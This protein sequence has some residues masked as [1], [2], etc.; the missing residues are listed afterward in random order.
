MRYPVPAL[1]VALASF[2][3]SG[4]VYA[5][6]GCAAGTFSTVTSPDGNATSFL[7][8]DFSATAGGASGQKSVTTT[9]KLNVPVTQP[10]GHG[11]YAV[12]YR[13]F[14]T[15]QEGQSA[16]IRALQDGREVLR[17]QIQGP[18]DD[19]IAL[20]NRIGVSDADALG[21]TVDIRAA[22]PLDDENFEAGLFLDTID[23]A[24]IGFTTTDSVVESM[25]Q[26][27]RQRQSIAI[28]LMPVAQTLLGQNNRTDDTSYLTTFAQSDAAAGFT[29]RWEAGSGISVLGGAA[30]VHPNASDVDLDTLAL[31]AG[32]LRYT[33][34]PA[35]W[36]MVGEVGAWGSPNVS[37]SLSRSYQNL[38][39][40]VFASGTASGSLLNAYGRV[41]VVYAPDEANEFS[42]S[43]RLT[44]S[45]LNL[46]GYAEDRND[47]NL[48]AATTAS[49]TSTSD[50][51]SLEFAWS[52]DT[53]GKLDYTVLGAVGRTF[54]GKSGVKASVDWVGDVQ[55]EADDQNFA[56]L[57]GRIGWKLDD[58]WK[59][60][61]TIS[62]TF[63]EGSKP[64]WTFG[65]QLRASF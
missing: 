7:F 26:L 53:G 14:V 58:R 18:L 44:R 47:S 19:D 42:L 9:C 54:A 40:M 27:A 17:Y 30:I 59:V 61:T 51:A 13:G 1:L 15:T 62:T 35:T 25:N 34:A 23:L 11:V 60:D 56:S 38:D 63:R 52:H 4:P 24:R 46:D 39:N 49:G 43:T 2:Q 50:T 32:A 22:G 5:A 28:D 36:R 6:N 41:G 21:L 31:F 29:G 65:G 45:W 37:A 20:S 55:G 57:G 48:F 33:T 10:N 16:S 8:D 12:D 64:D 3:L